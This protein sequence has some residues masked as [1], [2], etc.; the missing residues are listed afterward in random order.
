M[1]L[2]KSNLVIISL[3]VFLLTSFIVCDGN[4]DTNDGDVDIKDDVTVKDDLCNE[5]DCKKADSSYCGCSKN[6]GETKVLEPEKLVVNEDQ[7]K[8]SETNRGETILK[9]DK[10]VL[11][12]G[13][14]MKRDENNDGDDEKDVVQTVY[15]ETL[16]HKEDN[17]WQTF[18]G[19]Y[20]KNELVHLGGGTFIMG[21]DDS[22]IPQDG[23]APARTV[24]LNPFAIDKYEVSNGEFREFVLAT[25]HITEAEK[26]GDSFV[27]DYFLAEEVNKDIKQA[28]KD[29]QWWLPVPNA[30]WK[31]PEGKGSTIKDRLNHPVVHVSWNDALAYCRWKG[32]RLPTEAEWEYACRGGKQNRLFPWGN[33]YKPRDEHR[34][35][36][37][38]GNFPHN[39]TAEDGCKGTCEVDTF[40]QNNYKLHNMVGNV[41]EWVLDWWT[42][43]H[44]YKPVSNPRGPESGKDKVKKGGSFMCSKKF[45][46][47]YRCAARNFNSADSTASNLGFRCAQPLTKP[48]KVEL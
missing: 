7:E 47:R 1:R 32:S 26:F 48:S 27:M 40:L 12:D 39:N 46:Y 2:W 25:K 43:N 34:V 15:K 21:T 20:V 28:V 41:W 17:N 13:G 9:P 33:K 14:Q 23:E 10:L 3:L 45:C 18:K 16:F 5:N 37:W 24:I 31:Q 30:N 4:I 19:N 38:Q 42:T 11:G 36:I 29:A 35:N 44:S 8:R 22:P 6:R